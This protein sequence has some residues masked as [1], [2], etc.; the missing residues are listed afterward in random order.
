MFL[1]KGDSFSGFR[2]E[3]SHQNE[4]GHVFV[5]SRLNEGF[6]VKVMAEECFR[7]MQSLQERERFLDELA[8]KLHNEYANKRRQ[9]NSLQS[10][11]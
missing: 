7:A 5:F 10:N 6:V 4:Y 1:E 3:A 11:Q 8:I 2:V 9:T